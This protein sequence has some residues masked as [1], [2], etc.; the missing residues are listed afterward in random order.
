M[1]LV[2]DLLRFS[3]IVWKNTDEGVKVLPLPT[4]VS[5]TSVEGNSIQLIDHSH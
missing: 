5:H 3:S 4:F 1:P 2:K